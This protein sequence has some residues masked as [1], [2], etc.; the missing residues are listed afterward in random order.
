M[1]R[2]KTLYIKLTDDPE[3]IGFDY[4]LI[5]LSCIFAILA[6]AVGL[7]INI[8]L[9]FGTHII[10][11]TSAGLIFY[12]ILY[13]LA[14]FRRKYLLT[15]IIYILTLS[16]FLDILWLTNFGS[17]GPI[18]FIYI[19]VYTGFLFYLNGKQLVIYTI[20]FF[21]NTLGMFLIE[22]YSPGILGE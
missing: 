17:R 3:K 6:F 4:H 12:S 5:I 13:Y 7:V 22:Y 16:I 14:R 1:N 19:V 11:S 15:K 10:V 18:M 8:I 2:L 20:F 21:I 9:P